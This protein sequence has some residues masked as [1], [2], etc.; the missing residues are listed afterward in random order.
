M[1]VNSNFIF[2]SNGD[3]QID[4]KSVFLAVLICKIIQKKKKWTRLKDETN[5]FLQVF[6][7]HVKITLKTLER[8]VMEYTCASHRK[9]Y[10]DSFA[11]K[12]H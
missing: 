4:Q 3:F 5:V 10:S 11:G 12:C 6:L 7:S 9:A 8:K 2:R 1:R